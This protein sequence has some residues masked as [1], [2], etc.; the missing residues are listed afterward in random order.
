M[1]RAVDVAERKRLIADGWRQCARGQRPSQF[2]EQAEALVAAERERLRA[3]LM[4]HRDRHVLSHHVTLA[5]CHAARNALQLVMDE[6][7]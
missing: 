1:P 6:L 5:E 2:C 3:L 7:A 4:S